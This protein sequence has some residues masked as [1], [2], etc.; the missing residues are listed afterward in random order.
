MQRNGIQGS[1]SQHN[2]ICLFVLD[3]RFIITLSQLDNMQKKA[4]KII[5]INE[6]TACSQISIPSLTHRRDVAALTV[7]Y[8]MYTRHYPTD[9]YKLLPP[10]LKRKRVTPSSTFM[11]DHA[12]AV[13][14]VR[15]NSVDRSFVHSTVRIWNS[16]PA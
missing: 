11:P 10:P 9:L 14:D 7:F 15:T 2:G 1:S 8:K 13:P 4:L 16:L 12:L 5:G 6:A 3:K